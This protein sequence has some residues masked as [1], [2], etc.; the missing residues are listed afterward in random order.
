M[1]QAESRDDRS[2]EPGQAAERTQLA[3]TRSALSLGAIGVLF[4]HAGAKSAPEALAYPLGGLSL[5]AAVVV[6][7]CVPTVRGRALARGDLAAHRGLLRSMSA[8]IATLG[9]VAGVVVAISAGMAERPHQRT[10]A[11][12]G[13]R[14]RLAMRATRSQR[15]SR[16]IGPKGFP[17]RRSSSP[18]M[19][20]GRR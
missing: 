9:V 7:M 18:W 17:Q 2:P 13:E 8:G 12:K 4:I 3:W 10:S 15:T 20:A 16:S 19:R 11:H 14:A 6:G 1:L 5:L